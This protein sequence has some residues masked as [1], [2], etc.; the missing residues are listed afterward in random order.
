MEK[1]GLDASKVQIRALFLSRGDINYDLHS[2]AIKEGGF[3]GSK[4]SC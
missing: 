2:I 4:V 1:N 3:K